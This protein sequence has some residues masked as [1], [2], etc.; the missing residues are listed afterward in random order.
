MTRSFIFLVIV[1]GACTASEPSKPVPAKPPHMYYCLNIEELTPDSTGFV[2]VLLSDNEHEPSVRLHKDSIKG[3][4][5]ASDW[6]DTIF[7]ISVFQ[8]KNLRNLS[9]SMR[10]FKTIPPGISKLT[11]LES[12]NINYGSLM[13]LPEDFC[14]L[15][16]LR[17]ASFMYS[18]LSI[19]P[20]C[21]GQLNQLEELSLGYSRINKL[22]EGIRALTGLKHLLI[23]NTPDQP[24]LTM[25]DVKKL[26]EWLPNC[27][28]YYKIEPI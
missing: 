19:L 8:L 13:Y 16:S 27:E 24:H 22:P 18:A 1:F 10:G 21:I 12:L 3:L 14:N 7:P 15:S 28:I 20:D 17:S 25:E 26:T 9:M 6:A 11:K 23:Q 2:Q 4:I 5:L